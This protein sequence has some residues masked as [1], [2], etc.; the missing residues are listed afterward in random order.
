MN[1]NKEQCEHDFRFYEGCIGYESWV[2]S[3]C[4]L[5]INE[6]TGEE[7]KKW[8]D[9]CAKL[10]SEAEKEYHGLNHP[11]TGTTTTNEASNLLFKITTKL[12]GHYNERIKN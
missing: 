5:D 11:Q 3:K 7:R 12:G 9:W 1:K 2:C 4:G 10:E 8:A 6:A